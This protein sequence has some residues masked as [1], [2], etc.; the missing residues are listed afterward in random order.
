MSGANTLFSM[1]NQMGSGLGIAVGAVS[2]RLADLLHPSVDAVTGRDFQIAFGVVGA[3]AIPRIWISIGS[4]PT[5]PTRFAS[6]RLHP[7]AAWGD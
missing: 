5:P 6:A 2:L 7:D 4:R 3:L 1:M